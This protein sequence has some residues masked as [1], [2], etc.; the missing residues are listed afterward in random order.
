[1]YEYKCPYCGYVNTRAVETKHLVCNSCGHEF[2]AGAQRIVDI[3][4]PTIKEPD[5]YRE[6]TGVDPRKRF[7]TE[8]ICNL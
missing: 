8:F 2:N 4:Y 5:W 1:M 7:E 3:K 6:V